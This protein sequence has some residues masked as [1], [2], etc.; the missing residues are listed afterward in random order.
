MGDGKAI[1]GA[2]K[3][4][5]QLFNLK[6]DLAETNDLAQ[7]QPEMLKRL[8]AAA[9]ESHTPERKYPAESRKVTVND[10]VR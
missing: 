10:Y 4:E 7:E 9:K 3:S 8:L 5:G 6:Q 2:H 1:N